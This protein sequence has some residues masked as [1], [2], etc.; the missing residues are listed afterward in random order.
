MDC[1][2]QAISPLAC[3]F[4]EKGSCLRARI[5][6]SVHCYILGTQKTEQPKTKRPKKVLSAIL[7]NG[8]LSG[9]PCLRYCQWTYAPASPWAGFPVSMEQARA[10]STKKELQMG[11][12]ETLTKMSS[13]QNCRTRLNLWELDLSRQWQQTGMWENRDKCFWRHSAVEN[14]CTLRTERC[15]SKNSIVFAFKSLSFFLHSLLVLYRGKNTLLLNLT[16]WSHWD[17]EQHHKENSGHA[18]IQVESL[19]TLSSW[20]HLRTMLNTVPSTQ[21]TFPPQSTTRKRPPAW[22]CQ[23]E[24]SR[25]GS[26]RPLVSPRMLT[27]SWD[28]SKPF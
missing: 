2:I 9:D 16:E 19:G 17:V 26:T 18:G 1:F 4:H 25:N 27:H 20:V 13:S 22:G 6:C 15:S 21:L 10:K 24:N 7:W 11:A 5:V 28:Y 14:K 23:R 3:S 8:Q 12:D